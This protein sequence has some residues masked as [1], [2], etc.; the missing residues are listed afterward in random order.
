MLHKIVS[1]HQAG[2]YGVYYYYN[3]REQYPHTARG[4]SLRAV[5]GMLCMSAYS[6]LPCLGYILQAS[7]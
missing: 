3:A 6:R 5:C 4:R 7:N 2:K 1:A